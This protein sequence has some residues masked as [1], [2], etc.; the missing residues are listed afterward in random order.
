MV[1]DLR[2]TE[3]MASEEGADA[4]NTPDR[5]KPSKTDMYYIQYIAYIGRE[6]PIRRHKAIYTWVAPAG[7]ELEGPRGR[8]SGPGAGAQGPRGSDPSPPAAHSARDK[9]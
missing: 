9:R 2:V 7:A 5:V 3:E 4:I 8:G 6:T 1:R